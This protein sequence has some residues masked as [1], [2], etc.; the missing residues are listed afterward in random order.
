M[1]QRDIFLYE[2]QRSTNA[3]TSAFNPLL[4]SISHDA[5]STVWRY[6][7]FGRIRGAAIHGRLF[8]IGF[9]PQQ[10]FC[11]CCSQR[12]QLKAAHLLPTSPAQRRGGRGGDSTHHRSRRWAATAQ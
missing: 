9:A 3:A 7:E 12:C 2:H 5:S 10:Q 4:S 1:Q 8:S 6:A 11:A